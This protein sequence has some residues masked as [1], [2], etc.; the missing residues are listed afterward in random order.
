M[1]GQ[2]A[3]KNPSEFAAELLDASAEQAR[4]ALERAGTRAAE[5]VESWVRAGNAAAV[6]VAAD[7]ADGAAR[8]AARRG[9]NVL[10]S[11]KIAIPETR[12]VMKLSGA[13][14]PETRTAW[15][16]PPDTNGSVLLV[17]A[18]HS[19]PRRPRAAFVYVNDAFGVH[20]IDTGELGMSQLKEAMANSSPGRLF[21]P[22]SVPVNW[23]R[24][25]VA[26]ALRRH[27][28]R[29]EAAPLG[30]ASARDLLEPVPPE[31]PSHPFDDEGLVLSDEDA[32]D[33]AAESG[34][35]HRQ[36]EFRSWLPPR[37]AVDALLAAVG[38][39]FYADEQPDP[40]ALRRVLEEQVRAATDR[41]FSPQGR[42][43]L[44]ALMKD[45]ALSVLSRDGEQAA[46]EVV[47]AIKAISEA[48]LITN[49]PHEIG[50]LRGYFEKALAVL[51]QQEGGRL[52]IPL[53]RRRPTP[54]GGEEQAA[55]ST[56]DSAE[57][58]EV[59]LEP[60]VGPSSLPVDGSA[61][62]AG[63]A[64][65]VMAPLDAPAPADTG[66][67]DEGWEEEKTEKS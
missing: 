14:A 63:E 24:W 53:R 58:G 26:A 27:A 19:P 61:T 46:L 18:S 7:Q 36:P 66:L 17:V 67:V 1:S 25:R 32:K 4:A 30:L 55:A 51:H 15:M 6:A 22:V 50:F 29:G 45:S 13:P 40:D 47:A 34:R 48:G 44:V 42:E 62:F 38:A 3:S 54:E 37:Q 35:L 12:R 65:P 41:F 16:L 20:R 39:E 59:T 57:P 5:L 28:E 56:S 21:K 11:R 9:I 52:R 43:R 2:S 49:P 33:L 10:K 64:P 31:A 23:V 60:T 8:K